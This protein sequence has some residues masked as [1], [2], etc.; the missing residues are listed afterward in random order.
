MRKAVEPIIRR[1]G[2][3]MQSYQHPRVDAKGRHADF[4][5]EADVAVQTLLIDELSKTFPAARFFAEEKDGNVL[6][7]EF[8]FTNARTAVV[9]SV[10]CGTIYILRMISPA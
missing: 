7:P 1:A 6:T 8:T 10:S 9:S 4:V 3:L 2:E 5:T